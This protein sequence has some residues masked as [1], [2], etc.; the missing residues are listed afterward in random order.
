MK[1]GIFYE[2]QLPRPW[3]EG[4]EQKLFQ[5]GGS[6]VQAG[7]R[8]LQS[9]YAATLRMIARDGALIIG[10]IDDAGRSRAVSPIDHGRVSAWIAG[11]RETRR[12]ADGCTFVTRHRID[13]HHRC[14]IERFDRHVEERGGGPAVVI[15]NRH[16]LAEI[17]FGDVG[18]PDGC[19]IAHVHRGAVH[20]GEGRRYGNRQRR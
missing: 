7:D 3:V 18:N 17:R 4:A 8:L 19:R 11:V 15:L 13:R 5:P 12:D 6:P 2:H 1:F 10:K 14:G 20:I 9:D 16:R